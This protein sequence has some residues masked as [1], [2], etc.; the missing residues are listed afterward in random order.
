[1]RQ[2][3]MLVY[4]ELGIERPDSRA[5]V[6]MSEQMRTWGSAVSRY[7]GHRLM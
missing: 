3:A 5:E 6:V 7:T 1:M 2:L 4:L